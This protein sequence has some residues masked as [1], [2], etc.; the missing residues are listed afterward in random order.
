[1]DAILNYFL[2]FIDIYLQKIIINIRNR[3]SIKHA[4]WLFLDYGF[5]AASKTG[6][7]GL[8]AAFNIEILINLIKI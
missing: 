2:Y 1:M 3:C 8:N 7:I 6:N 4:F 5:N